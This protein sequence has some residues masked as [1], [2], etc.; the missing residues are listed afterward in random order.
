MNYLIK[1]MPNFKK[2]DS[3]LADVK[4]KVSPILLSGLSDAGKI[5]FAYATSFYTQKPIC[6]VTY[7]EMQAR[8][9]IK[10]MKYFTDN[11]YF[12]PKKDLVTYDY[13]A[14]SKETTYQRIEVLNAIKNKKSRSYC[15]N[16]RSINARKHTVYYSISK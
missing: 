2:F 14:E 16:N 7:N 4:N 8:K 12:F 1:T 3:Y 5:H 11:V 9:V 15:N 6:F 13:I 10:D